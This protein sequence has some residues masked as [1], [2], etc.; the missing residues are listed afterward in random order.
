MQRCTWTPTSG[1]RCTKRAARC[2]AH[3][4]TV[5]VHAELSLAWRCSSPAGMHAA[6]SGCLGVQAAAAG[7]QHKSTDE[8]KRQLLTAIKANEGPMRCAC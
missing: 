5:Q 1:W 2:R 3:K 6:V 7:V 4:L 8:L